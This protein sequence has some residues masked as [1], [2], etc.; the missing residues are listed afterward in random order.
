MRKALIS[1]LVVALAVLG[2]SLAAAAGPAKIGV[3]DMAEVYKNS[4]PGQA[5]MQQIKTKFDG[6]NA[7]LERKKKEVAKLQE[8]LEKQGMALSLEARQDKDLELRRKMRDYNDTAQAYQQKL[9]LEE[10]RLNE[11]IIKLLQDVVKDFGT[12]HGFTLIMEKSS[13]FGSSIVFND[14]AVD[15]TTQVRDELNKAWKA[16]P[17]K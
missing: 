12:K 4:E 5:A 13:R 9:Q 8:E 3:V 1:T 15:V 11:P 2:A 7:E 16:R 17:K 6:M 14:P 10:G